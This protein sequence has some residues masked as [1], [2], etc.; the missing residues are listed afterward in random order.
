M[1]FEKIRDKVESQQDESESTLSQQVNEII[2][3]YQIEGMEYLIKPGRKHAFFMSPH[4]TR[5]FAEAEELFSDITYTGNED[6]T[7]MLNMVVFNASTMH[8]QAVVRVLCDKQDGE[9]YATSFREVFNKMTN[10]Y[11]NFRKG[12]SLKKNIGRF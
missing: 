3:K 4:Q 2:G 5:L 8:Y 7:Y 6:F 10:C 11:P 12:Q 9:S 1:E